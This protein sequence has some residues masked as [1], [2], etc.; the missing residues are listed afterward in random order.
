MFAYFNTP[1]L[2]LSLL[3]PNDWEQEPFVSLRVKHNVKHRS[4]KLLHSCLLGASI[5]PDSNVLL[6][7]RSFRHN[8][9]SGKTCSHPFCRAYLWLCFQLTLAT[10]TL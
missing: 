1:L 4:S 9:F 5:K 3:L 7:S 8:A 10:V 6:P 2:I